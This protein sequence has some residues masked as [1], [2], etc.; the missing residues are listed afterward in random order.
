MTA[1][2]LVAL[3]KF[4]F[5][6]TSHLFHFTLLTEVKPHNTREKKKI[7]CFKTDQVRCYFC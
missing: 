7:N 6:L 1:T 5:P 3:Y 2:H 4:L